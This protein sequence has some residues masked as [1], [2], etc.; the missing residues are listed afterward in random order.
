MSLHVGMLLF[1][2]FTQLDLTGPYEV[3]GKFTDTSIHLIAASGAP[4]KSAYGARL[5]IVPTCTFDECPRLDVLFVP[6]GPGIFNAMDDPRCLDLLRQQGASARF[7]TSVCTGSLIL[8]AAGLLTDYRATT[9]WQSLEL[10][11]IVGAIPV[12]ERV[13]VDRNRVTGAGV[14]SGIDFALVLATLLFG[15]S[16]SK[17][18]QLALE[19]DPA[20]PFDSGSPRSA[21]TNLVA[22]LN[23]R[24]APTLADRRARLQALVDRS[25][26]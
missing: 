11:P 21:D 3:F 6:E 17:Q 24:F 10:L 9:H 5:Q 7:V 4:V 19:Y 1:E 22:T 26:S 15:E 23:A 12:A 8:G 16:T 20:P 14:T 18:I 2:D 13:V 25:R